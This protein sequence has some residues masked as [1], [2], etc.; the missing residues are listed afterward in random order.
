MQ[1]RDCEVRWS[2]LRCVMS[3]GAGDGIPIPLHDADDRVS[4]VKRMEIVGVRVELPANTP[5]VLLQETDG[6]RRLLPIYIGNPEAAAIHSALEGITPPR[7]LTHDLLVDLVAAL[8]AEI[9]G[10]TITDVRDHTFYAELVLSN[11]AGEQ[12]TVSC[13]P[14]DACAVAVRV[15]AA[16]YADES[17]LDAAGRVPAE[18]EPE[19]EEIIDEFHDFLENVN[20]EDFG[21][22]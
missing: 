3:S 6:D 19:A 10:V 7:P 11:A 4:T 8:G 5:M 2:M 13:R 16:V 14:S 22:S 1:V 9:T 17:V 20:P 15:G 12:T 18:E 21:A